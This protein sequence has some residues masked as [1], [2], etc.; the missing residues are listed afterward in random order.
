MNDLP[1]PF[2]RKEVRKKPRRKGFAL[3][4]DFFISL[5]PL[6]Q[7]FYSITCLTK[8]LENSFLATEV[9]SIHH[10]EG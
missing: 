5:F 4:R 7:T 8:L 3:Q 9:G 6:L 1:S 2:L 10:E